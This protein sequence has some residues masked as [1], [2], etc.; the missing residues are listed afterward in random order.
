[1]TVDFVRTQGLYRGAAKDLRKRLRKL[2]VGQ[3][4]DNSGRIWRNLSLN[5]RD[6]SIRVSAC[7]AVARS[8]K[9]ASASLSRWNGSKPREDLPA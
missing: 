6:S 1:M 4:P 3:T 8:L 9:R 7:L 2:S 5:R